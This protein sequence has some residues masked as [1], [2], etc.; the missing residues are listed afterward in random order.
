[1]ARIE[2]SGIRKSF[3]TTEVLRGVDLTVENGEFLSLVGPSGCGKSTLLRIIAGLE[4]QS[5]GQVTIDGSAVV[6]V[7]ARAISRWCSSPMRSI[8]I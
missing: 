1:M 7:R 2:L 3:D 5:T 6:S 4:P 8:R